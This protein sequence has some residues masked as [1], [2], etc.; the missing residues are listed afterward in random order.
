M[1]HSLIPGETATYRC[2][3]TDVMRRSY[4]N[5]NKN[6]MSYHLVD[7]FQIDTSK[8]MP[9]GSIFKRNMRSVLYRF[10]AQT[11]AGIPGVG[12]EEVK[13]SY[14]IIPSVL[15]RYMLSHVHV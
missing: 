12:H 4:N 2:V 6:G 13:K 5:Q 3:Q 1:L 14:T 10:G 8:E 9:F 11:D 15:R 7:F